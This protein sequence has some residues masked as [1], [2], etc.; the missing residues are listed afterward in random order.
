MPR[1]PLAWP[2]PSISSFSVARSSTAPA[3]PACAPTSASA[4]TRSSPSAISP[5]PRRRPRS[6]PDGQVVAPGFIDLLGNSQ[7][8]VLIDPRLEGKIR[9]GVTTEVTGEGHSPGPQNDAM[10]A[11]MERRSRRAGRASPGTRSASSCASSRSTAPRS[12]SRSTSGPR[13]RARWSSA[14]ADRAPTAEELQRMKAIVKQA[15]DEGASGVASA[16]IYPPGRFATTEELIAHGAQPAAR[17][18]RTCA[19]R[20]T[21]SSRPSTRP[22]ASA[23][24]RTCRSTSSISRS[25]GGRTGDGCRGDREEDRGGAEERRRHRREHLSIH[26][27]VDRAHLD[28]AGVGARRRLPEARGATEAIPPR[29]RASRS[30]LREGRLRNGGAILIV[31]RGNPS[32]RLDA[33]AKEMNVDPAEAV[34]R[35][36]EIATKNRRSPS[37][38]RSA[39]RT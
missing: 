21:T 12:I 18:G 9:Q 5:T 11:E 26:R 22:S 10:L 33:I 3:L 15:V 34:L 31:I 32:K 17:T 23:A 28:R 8:A 29:G 27:H 24:R 39:K 35:L 14:H 2:A 36:F 38:S 1:V 19:T 25:A 7:A 6:T 16:L 13:T 30:E 20:R 4:A 37:S